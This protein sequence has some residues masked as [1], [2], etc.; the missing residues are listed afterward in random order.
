[1]LC[2][3]ELAALQCC[4]HTSLG[5]S[6]SYHVVISWDRPPADGSVLMWPDHGQRCLLPAQ[7]QPEASSGS[8]IAFCWASFLKHPSF[9]GC[10]VELAVTLQPAFR[11]QLDAAAMFLTAPPP[12]ADENTLAG[13]GPQDQALWSSSDGETGLR[14]RST[15]FPNP[16]PYPVDLINDI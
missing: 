14:L 12:L 2:C 10:L 7:A 4:S 6:I 13:A 11:G 8:L 5:A 1:M 16:W 9:T 3:F 15:P